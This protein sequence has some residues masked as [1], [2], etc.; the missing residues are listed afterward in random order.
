MW[1]VLNV[2]LLTVLC[3]L[4]P[5]KKCDMVLLLIAQHLK[6]LDKTNIFVGLVYLLES[7]LEGEKCDMY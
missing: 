4:Q 5:P 6:S 7:S 3:S 2:T 1:D